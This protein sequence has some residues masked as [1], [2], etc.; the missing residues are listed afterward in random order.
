MLSSYICSRIYYQLS[1][2]FPPTV[3]LIRDV[4]QGCYT[5]SRKIRK[6][7]DIAGAGAWRTLTPRGQ[8]SPWR[9][10]QQNYAKVT[11]R[12]NMLHQMCTSKMNTL[13][14]RNPKTFTFPSPHYVP[15]RTFAP[16]S[17]TVLFSVTCNVRTPARFTP[18]SAWP[19]TPASPLC[20]V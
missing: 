4:S 20:R 2:A 6:I 10:K 7:F 19:H 11:E 15:L 12:T 16:T 1:Q 17:R 13:Y 9:V 18:L 3:L 8:R 5:R 14:R